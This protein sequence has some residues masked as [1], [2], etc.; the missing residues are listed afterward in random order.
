MRA[1]WMSSRTRNSRHLPVPPLVLSLAAFELVWLPPK[2]KMREMVG[3]WMGP[4][5]ALLH[6]MAATRAELSRA[7]KLRPNL[8]ACVGTQ[9][10]G[11]GKATKSSSSSQD[12][13]HG[14]AVTPGIARSAVGCTCPVQALRLRRTGS[15]S[16]DFSYYFYRDD[17]VGLGFFFCPA[18]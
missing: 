13:E 15:V 8:A 7:G 12:L 5:A 9:R 14:V 10:P 11:L 2:S 3:I 1:A 4:G 18:L 6:L 16:S 17:E